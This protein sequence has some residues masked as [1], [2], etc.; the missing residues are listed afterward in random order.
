MNPRK[1][2]AFWKHIQENAEAEEGTWQEDRPARVGVEN[3][4]SRLAEEIG[5]EDINDEDT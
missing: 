4:L 5:Q 2:A 3:E 1:Q